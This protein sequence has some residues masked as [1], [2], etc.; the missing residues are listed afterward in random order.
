MKEDMEANVLNYMLYY[1]SIRSQDF[2]NL[3]YKHLI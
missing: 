2:D 3:E 1:V